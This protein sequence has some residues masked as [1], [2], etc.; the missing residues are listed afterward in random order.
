MIFLVDA[1]LY[2]VDIDCLVRLVDCSFSNVNEML[3]YGADVTS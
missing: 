3:V 1:E 2:V